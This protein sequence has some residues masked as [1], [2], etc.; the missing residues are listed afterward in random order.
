M[1]RFFVAIKPQTRKTAVNV[2]KI[3]LQAFLQVV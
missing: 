2:F 3:V 1:P